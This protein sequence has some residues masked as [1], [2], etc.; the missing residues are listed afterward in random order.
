M[1]RGMKAPNHCRK[2]TMSLWAKQSYFGHQWQI[3]VR[4]REEDIFPTS[5]SNLAVVWDSE[6]REESWAQMMGGWLYAM[7]TVMLHAGDQVHQHAE[8]WED[9]DGEIHGTLLWE[10]LKIMGEYFAGPNF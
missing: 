2:K 5:D 6:V 9:A 3:V 4:I 1:V 10:L 8:C 7:V